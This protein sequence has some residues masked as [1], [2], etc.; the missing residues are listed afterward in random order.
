[1]ISVYLISDCPAAFHYLALLRIENPDSFRNS[2][3]D[4]FI[5]YPMTYGLC[6]M[7]YKGQ[8]SHAQQGVAKDWQLGSSQMCAFLFLAVLLG[9]QEGPEGGLIFRC[10]VLVVLFS[11]YPLYHTNPFHEFLEGDAIF[12]KMLG[13]DWGEKRIHLNNCIHRSAHKR[14]NAR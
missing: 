3:N 6:L 13:K 5:F 4:G 11:Q 10:L 8:G 14:G 9:R 1:M 2:D 12:F 7:V